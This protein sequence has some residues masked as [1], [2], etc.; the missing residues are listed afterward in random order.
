MSEKATS[1]REESKDIQADERYVL[2]FTYVC[3]YACVHACM[4]VVYAFRSDT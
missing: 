1:E 3:I 4:N 2:T